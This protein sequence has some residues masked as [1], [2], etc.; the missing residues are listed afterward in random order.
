[1]PP[2]VVLDATIQY[3]A[4]IQIDTDLKLECSDCKALKVLEGA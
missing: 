2:P 1:M 3:D 4:T